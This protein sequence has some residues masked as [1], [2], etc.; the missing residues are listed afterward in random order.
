MTTLC[1]VLPGQ[2]ST[3]RWDWKVALRWPSR[4]ALDEA[5]RRFHFDDARH[6]RHVGRQLAH[7][8]QC[9]RFKARPSKPCGVCGDD[10]VT[11]DGK[12]GDRL[13]FDRAY[14]FGTWKAGIRAAGFTPPNNGR[15]PK[16][17]A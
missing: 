16:A 6:P 5:W 7:C 11:Y 1:G 14:L 12:G 8:F 2:S 9:G 3:G 4:A 15:K 17:T 10:P 13:S